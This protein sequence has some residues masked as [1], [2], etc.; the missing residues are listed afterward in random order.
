M[1]KRVIQ[2]VIVED[3]LDGTEMPE[4][5]AVE[6][7]LILDADGTTLWLTPENSERLR[8]AVA[9][10]LEVGLQFVATRGAGGTAGV[11]STA[12][13]PSGTGSRATMAELFTPDEIAVI[14]D[15]AVKTDQIIADS[16]PAHGSRVTVKFG[17][18]WV[19]KGRPRWNGSAWGADVNPADDVAKHHEP[20]DDEQEV[21]ESTHPVLVMEAA[22]VE[23]PESEA[24]AAEADEPTAE[25]EPEVATEPEA[26]ETEAAEPEVASPASNGHHAP[27]SETPK[28]TPT[29]RRAA[30]KS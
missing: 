20:A 14:K 12:T 13:A 30:A 28:T 8:A 6:H 19:S 4:D 25:A 18:L 24:P 26:A 27:F 29:R 7:R 15:W 9:P 21:T 16:R 1:G 2:T 5:D 11:T 23:V 22:E 17:H 3:D 10:F